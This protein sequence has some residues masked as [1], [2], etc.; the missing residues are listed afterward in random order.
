MGRRS[1]WSDP[2][3]IELTRKFVAVTDEVW[4]LQNCDDSEC[5]HFQKIADVGHY[6]QH[7]SSRQGIYVCTASGILLGSLNTHNVDRVTSLLRLSLEKY[8]DLKPKERLLDDATKILPSHRWEQSKPAVGLELTMFAR[9]LPTSGDPSDAPYSNWN[10]DRVWFSKSEARRFLPADLHHLK[11]GD[12]YSVPAELVA[13]FARFNIVDT[14]NGQTTHYSSK[15]I[16]GSALTATI[17]QLDEARIQLKIAGQ[18]HAESNTSRGRNM[19]HGIRT[20]VFGHATFDRHKELFTQFEIVAIGS[21][22]GQT[23]FNRRSRKLDES[24]VGFVFRIT[25]PDAPTI[26][27]AFIY[28][29][30]AKWLTRPQA[31]D[32]T[33]R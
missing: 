14:V 8:N 12:T 33:K 31:L 16:S 32:K 6:R 27:P 1:I 20:R 13:R 9:D 28:A 26:A 29:Y 3:I 24:P 5:K 7:K 19:P 22:W 17:K 25:A 2:K 30:D 18:T 11:T 23:T 4:R 21:R 10:Q 15:E